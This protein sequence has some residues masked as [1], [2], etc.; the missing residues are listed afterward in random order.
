MNPDQINI[1]PI[2]HGK[3]EFAF[4]VRRRFFEFQP[5]AVAVELP[6]T[7]KDQVIKAV[8]RLPL[9][10][11]VLYEEANGQTVYFP[12][13][14][15]DGI[16][17]GIRLAGEKS[18]PI[19]FIDRDVEGYAPKREPMPDPYAIARIG[20]EVYSQ[21]VAEF[22]ADL[23]PD[24]MDE[25]RERTMAY[26]IQRLQGDYNRILCVIGLAHYA[27]LMQALSEP[28]AIPLGRVHREKVKVAHL[29][30]P[31][32]REILSETPFLIAAYEKARQKEEG[33]MSLDRTESQEELL[34]EARKAHKKNSRETVTSH[35]IKILKQFARNYAL[36]TGQLTPDFYQ[37]LIA[38][39]GAVND[40]FAYEVWEI[41]ST[42]P[43][44]EAEPELP[45]L[46]LRGE[47]LFLDE[48]RIRFFRRLLT[49]RTRLVPVPVKKRKKE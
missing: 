9:L 32:S 28:Q 3:L 45:V 14:P 6:R 24:Q 25:M 36:L 1:V 43:W 10:S 47:D 29:A 49:Q 12:I 48:K 18:I 27:G 15:Q 7:L 4:E 19:Y 35:E 30:E 34:W 42:Y 13:E 40:N 8:Q 20:F 23:I 11:V 33:A 21:K 22:Y 44:Q 5:E 17:E 16:V 39:R 38:S 31:S 2:L 46:R 37:L 41:G 26:H